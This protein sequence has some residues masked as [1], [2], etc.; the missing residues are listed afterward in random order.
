MR[1]IK[2]TSFLS[3]VFGL[4]IVTTN[5]QATTE[6][7]VA[8]VNGTPILASEV[9]KALGKQ[10]DTAGNRMKALDSIIDDMLVQ[11]A[12]KESGVT[13]DNRQVEKI[14]EKI[15]A[16]NGLTYGQLLDALDYQGISLSQFRKNITNQILM[17][18]VRNRSI[19]KH[20]DVTREQ[21]EELSK[22]MLKGAK[23]SDKVMGTQYKVRHIL[24]KLTPVL[25]DIQA[26]TTLASVRADILAGKISFEEAAKKYSKDFL[27]GANGGDLGFAFPEAY[28]H[29]FGEMIKKTPRGIISEPFKSEF[30]WHILEVMDTKMADRTE[31]AYRQKAYENLVNQ[32]LQEDSRDWIRALRKGAEIKYFNE[33]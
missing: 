4:F 31:D 1:T 19:G 12:I 27:S 22:Q 17:A 11:K 30:G 24:L 25:N 26:K 14:I 6:R 13:V 28:V 33:K 3:L 29:E 8:T 32:Q 9:Q 23:A 15:A 18:E 20:I 5:V 21:V 16:D 7:V 10:A 2:L